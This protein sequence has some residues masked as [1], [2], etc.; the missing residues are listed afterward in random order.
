LNLKDKKR[1]SS[2]FDNEKREKRG[3]RREKTIGAK[4][5]HRRTHVSYYREKDVDVFSK[6]PQ[7]VVF[8]VCTLLHAPSEKHK[9]RPL[10]VC[11]SRAINFLFLFLIFYITEK[12][13]FP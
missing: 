7:K 10:V 5:S 9:R 13:K 8:D 12:Q 11:L 4:L 1:T 6:P 3:K 2:Y